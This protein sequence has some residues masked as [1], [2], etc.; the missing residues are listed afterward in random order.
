MNLLIWQANNA[1]REIFFRIFDGIQPEF[2]IW[3]DWLVNPATKRPLKLDLN[4]PQLGVAVRFEGMQGKRKQR[5]SLEEEAQQKTRDR[6]RL[7]LCRANGIELIA[8]DIAGDEPTAI[9]RDV[10][11]C[12]SR[13][14]ERVTRAEA[15]QQIKQARAIAADLSRR[16]RQTQD[17]RL[18]ADLW[19]DRQHRLAEPGPAS[20]LQPVSREQF[21]VGMAVEHVA[22][23]NGIITNIA[24][25]ADDSFLTVD[26]VTAGQK[27]L[28]TSLVAGKLTVK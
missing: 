10:D 9:F 23:G 6:A 24:D 5:L 14:K 21:K 19:N 15:E 12:L 27:I 18:Y 1:W 8:V 26:F 4:Y 20:V 25:N 7:D 3:P 2:N 11:M 22:F 13:A 28:A 17:L 16:V